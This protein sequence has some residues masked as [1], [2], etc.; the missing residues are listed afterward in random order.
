MINESEA[1][2]LKVSLGGTDQQEG[3]GIYQHRGWYNLSWYR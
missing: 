2:E 1:I 3:S